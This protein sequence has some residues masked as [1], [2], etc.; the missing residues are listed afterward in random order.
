MASLA[1]HW[2]PLT[3]QT[4]TLM[5]VKRL[6]AVTI[7]YRNVVLVSDTMYTILIIK[8]KED[9]LTPVQMS[10]VIYSISASS[11]MKSQVSFSEIQIPSKTINC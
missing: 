8:K 7:R 1:L 2:L 4:L 11:A 9:S 10:G 3:S 6:N 5:C